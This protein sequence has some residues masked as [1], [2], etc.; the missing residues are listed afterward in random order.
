RTL[1]L[2]TEGVREPL[3]PLLV[4]ALRRERF[5]TRDQCQVELTREHAPGGVVDE[6]LRGGATDAR[7]EAVTRVGAD[8]LRK[9][10]DRVVVL[11]GLAVDD[12]QTLEPAK[13]IGVGVRVG[14]GGAG[15]VFPHGKRF[16]RALLADVVG[17]PR[18]RS[19]PD[20]ARR[21]SIYRAC[22][23]GGLFSAKAFGP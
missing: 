2:G 12:L 13:Q 23:T 10:R 7:V 5:R 18:V 3:P 11:R 1:F 8:A 22:H 17:M 16:G 15:D 14:R 9:T 4:G 19:N 21:L 20:D 6:L